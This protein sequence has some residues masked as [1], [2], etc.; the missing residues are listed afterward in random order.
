[1]RGDQKTVRIL[2]LEDLEKDLEY[3]ETE[4]GKSKRADPKPVEAGRP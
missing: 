4:S 3:E 1:M 2:I